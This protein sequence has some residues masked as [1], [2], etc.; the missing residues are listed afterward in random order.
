MRGLS[1]PFCLL[2]KSLLDK[3]F[4]DK[5]FLDKRL[6]DKSFLD[7]PLLDK[8][9]L[10]KFFLD[11]RLME[12]NFHGQIVSDRSSLDRNVPTQFSL[13][14]T[15]LTQVS[16]YHIAGATKVRA[17]SRPCASMRAHDL[18]YLKCFSSNSEHFSTKFR[19]FS[20][21]KP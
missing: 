1:C 14:H 16:V 7:K 10:A 6:L 2:D 19:F 18:S 20:N 5:I 9:F 15:D 3:C 11:K 4:L 21:K 8:R 17:Q 13:G 12:K